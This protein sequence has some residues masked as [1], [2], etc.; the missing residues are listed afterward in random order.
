MNASIFGKSKIPA[1]FRSTFGKS[2]ESV[3]FTR[4]NCKVGK[5]STRG[6][7]FGQTDF[8]M[9]EHDGVVTDEQMDAIDLPVEIKSGVLTRHPVTGVLSEIEFKDFQHVSD[10]FK[11]KDKQKKKAIDGSFRSLVN[12]REESA[13]F[14]GKG[15]RLTESQ[16]NMN[17]MRIGLQ[18]ILGLNSFERS[19]EINAGV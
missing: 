8:P 12:I 18:G 10:K 4:A 7:L 19:R 11:M 5:R 1:P 13:G 3:K 14:G 2:L 17:S 9:N 16:S 15:R 6:I